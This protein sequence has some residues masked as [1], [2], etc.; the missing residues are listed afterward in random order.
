MATINGSNRFDILL[1]TR[2]NDAINGRGGID[3]VFGGGGDDH[4]DGGDGSDLVFGGDGDDTL[5]GGDGR[6]SL[7]G[8]RGNDVLVADYRDLVV[9]GGAGTDIGRFDF[10][11]A[12]RS[13]NFEVADNLARF[14]NFGGTFV[15]GVEQ[16]DVQAGRGNDHITG[17]TFDDT[18]RGGNGNDV[19][20]G[21]AGDDTLLGE[22]GRDRL[23]G[24]TGD[25][26]LD[27]GNGDDL[28]TGGAGADRLVG[29]AG[30]DVLRGDAGANAI[31]GGA[32]DDSAVYDGRHTDFRVERLDD[33]GARIV[34]TR[35]GHVLD[36]VVHNVESFVFTDGAFTLDQLMPVNH[37]PVAVDDNYVIGEDSFLTVNPI[38]NDSDPDGHPIE[39]ASLNYT[40]TTGHVDWSGG[41]SIT[42]SAGDALQSLGEGETFTD[43][44]LYSV[45]DDQGGPATP[46]TIHITVTGTNDAPI[47]LGE[48]LSLEADQAYATIDVLANDGD[49]DNNDTLHIGDFDAQSAEGASVT[50]VDGK[51][52]YDAGDAFLNL[53][54]G[55]TL[56]DSFDY[57]VVDSHGAV[58]TATAVVTIH[59][60]DV[61]EPRMML[62]GTEDMTTENFYD[63]VLGT[64]QYVFGDGVTIEGL[65]THGL[66]GTIT[67]DAD[68]HSMTYT[69][70]DP[71][72]EP[73]WGDYSLDTGFTVEVRTADG[74]VEEF[75][76]AMTIFGV[77][78]PAVAGDDYVTIEVGETT[79]NLID[80]LLSNDTD[81]DG[82]AGS[83]NAVDLQGLHGT[84]H[85][86]RDAQTITYEANPAAFQDLAPGES[87]EETFT[88][89]YYS[90]ND[91]DTAMVHLTIM[92]PVLG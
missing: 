39:L 33:G 32:G 21:G 54:E 73:L 49:V 87:L 90:G 81:P 62:Y 74:S 3:L 80:L 34:D 65:D 44:V 50:M 24:G 61:F 42:Y 76:V 89:D 83:I 78:D 58:S 86:D 92:Q 29:G 15:H 30:A 36:D 51:L 13:I 43:T 23:D 6:D 57:Q 18:I 26:S 72:L 14:S 40:Q 8:G 68:A 1:G 46:G 2:S 69:G 71:A 75:D 60:T 82:G 35:S 20:V 7:D 66:L 27:G 37:D 88:Y 22:E 28:L 41:S 56:T 11:D 25:D 48:E 16:I 19:L 59:G 45:R 79:G 4:I 10:H 53:A 67:Y 47:A 55:E 77:N 38:A 12:G 85:F 52:V 84:L 64:A 63:Q 17:G 91:A 9:E 31:D 70:D 5:I